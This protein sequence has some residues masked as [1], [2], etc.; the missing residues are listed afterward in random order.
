[1]EAGREGHGFKCCTMQHH[2]NENGDGP[3]SGFCTGQCLRGNRQTNWESKRF[4]PGPVLYDRGQRTTACHLPNNKAITAIAPA[5]SIG[6]T[7]SSASTT[8]TEI[9]IRQNISSPLTAKLQQYPEPYNSEKITSKCDAIGKNASDRSHPF[10]SFVIFR[11]C[12]TGRRGRRRYSPRRGCYLTP[13]A[14]WDRPA[15]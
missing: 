9:T 8:A 5:N 3:G 4:S 7:H 2:E 15:P 6:K 10:V 13:R 14:L 1:V 12:S 11:Y